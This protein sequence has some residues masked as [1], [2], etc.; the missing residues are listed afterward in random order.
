[1]GKF[2]FRVTARETVDHQAALGAI[3]EFKL[4]YL[5]ASTQTTSA[6]AVY[7]RDAARA[8]TLSK[9]LNHFKTHGRSSILPSDVLNLQSV[10]AGCCMIQL[11]TTPRHTFDQDIFEKDKV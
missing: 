6:S 2:E 4:S 8:P 3:C 1:L 10:E 9:G 7:V 5:A 11:D